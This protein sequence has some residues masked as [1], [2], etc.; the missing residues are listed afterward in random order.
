M[1]ITGF[2]KCIREKYGGSFKKTWVDSYDH[3]YID[4]NFAL[5]YCS[6]GAKSIDEIYERLFK[7]FDNILQELTPAKSLTIAADGAAPLSKL[8]L[9]RKRRLTISRN[10]QKDIESS[11]LMFTPGTKF[12][13]EIKERMSKYM[14]YIEKAYCIKINYLNLNKDEAELKLKKK[15]MENLEEHVGDSHVVVTNDADVIVMLC[16]LDKF[17]NVYIFCKSNQQN[18]V[19][20]IGK[21]LDLHTDNVGCSVNP[22]LDFA[23]VSI[24]LGN[25]YLPKINFVT[26][27]KL[28]ISYKN[29]VGADPRGLIL[30]RKMTINKSFMIK[31]LS[32]VV[33]QTRPCF[34]K[35][36][37]LE[38]SFSSL[39]EN[40]LDGYTWCLDTYNTGECTRYNYMYGFHDSP[41]PLGL[42][43]GI[44][45]NPDFLKLS[46]EKFECIDSRL[47]AILVLPKS[48]LS[49][50][51]EKYKKFT[52]ETDILY[53][54]EC[55]KKCTS[56]HS[57]LKKLNEEFLNDPK[58]LEIKKKI[59]VESKS[60]TLHKKQHDDITLSD[61]NNIITGFNKFNSKF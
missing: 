27:D 32:G 52:E 20:S 24:M 22:G 35:R 50:V 51:D 17:H 1:G 46:N 43:F 38:F 11:S 5:H 12:M 7:F 42:M 56:F 33:I 8:L 16:T 23:A 19:I 3:V 34:I 49:L 13:N 57:K 45:K 47:Y 55:C 4:I 9:Q 36:L 10:L 44:L 30:D 39:Y 21:L 14:K 60:M 59:T 41:H 58:N 25:D 6:Y 31:L 40:Y 61:I 37:A 54:E 18:E 29:A 48:S 28:W 2:H 26:F 53:D 15:L